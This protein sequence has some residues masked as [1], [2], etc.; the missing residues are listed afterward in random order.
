[1]EA[2]FH[3][4]QPGDDHGRE[5]IVADRP[6]RGRGCDRRAAG[7]VRQRDEECVVG[8][9]VVVAR[10]LDRQRPRRLSR[11]ER[12][13]AAGESAAGKVPRVRGTGARAG[14]GVIDTGRAAGFARSGDS[15]CEGCRAGIPF[16]LVRVS[17]CDR[18]A[19]CD[20]R[21]KVN[22]TRGDPRAGWQIGAGSAGSIVHV[23]TG[24]ENVFDIPVVPGRSVVGR[25][26][27]R[28][29]RRGVRRARG[30][31]QG[32][33]RV[34]EISRAAVAPANAVQ[35][36]NPRRDVER[37]IV[38]RI[39]IHSDRAA[40]ARDHQERD[41]S[42]LHRRRRT[43]QID[44][45]GLRIDLASPGVLGRPVARADQG[46]AIRP[47][48][49]AGQIDGHVDDSSAAVAFDLQQ[50]QAGQ[51]DTAIARR[52]QLDVL[53]AVV[54]VRRIDVDLVQQHRI[55]I[56]VGDVYRDL[57]YGQSV[58]STIGTG[59]GEGNDRS[60]VAL[61]HRVVDRGD[62]DGLRRIGVSRGERQ[63]DGGPCPSAEIDL[64][65]GRRQRYGDVC[66]RRAGQR[67]LNRVRRAPLGHIRTAARLDHGQPR[68]GAGRGR[69]HHV[70]DRQRVVIPGVVE[71]GPAEPQRLAR[72]PG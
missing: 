50:P 7:R 5:I 66:G 27:A 57:G 34:D 11:G 1:M 58:K 15:E 22:R 43:Q 13:R 19:R 70:I 9:E 17:S 42:I 18:Q 33:G 30:L 61:D 24:A 69:E 48:G 64:G 12:D 35:Q 56:V 67:Q 37:P 72:R 68:R 63:N 65:V 31:G 2:A 54:N 32:R 47:C 8:F 26:V 36:C 55:E 25:V 39:Q 62:R 52:N 45:R 51:R 44:Q 6:R 28:E 14:D 21:T 71:I 40:E 29:S 4:R 49:K 23:E 38:V 46:Q 53:A 20:R 41:R 10:H 16:G 3:R 59:G 60:V